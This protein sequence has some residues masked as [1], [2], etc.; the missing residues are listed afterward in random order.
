MT[1]DFVIRFNDFSGGDSGV[2]DSSLAAG[3]Q[4][5]GENMVVYPSGL[6]GPRG[7]LK[8][9]PTRNLPDHTT[10]PGP[11]GFTVFN[12]SLIIVLGRLYALPIAG[13]PAVGWAPYPSGDAT[14]MVRFVVGN[15]TLYS[16]TNGV[17]HKHNGTVSTTAITTPAPLSEVVRWGYFFVGVDRN[18]PWRIWFNKVDQAGSDFDSWP[19]NNYVDVGNND[20]ITCLQPIF[21][22]LY[23]GKKEG[24]WAVSGVLGQL[25]SV[26]EVAIGNGPLDC[27]FTSVTTDNRIIYW[28][29]QNIPAW[30]NGERVTLESEQVMSPRFLPFPGDAVIVTPTARRLLLAGDDNQGGTRLFA[31]QDGAWQHLRAGFRLGALAPN[32]VRQGSDLPA[33]AIF[34]VARPTTIGDPAVIVSHVHELNRPAHHD[35]DWASPIDQPDGVDLISGSFAPT[36]WFDSQGRQVRVRWVQVQFRKWASGIAES[37]NRLTLRVESLGPYGAGSEMSDPVFWIEPCERSPVAGAND[38]W[39]VNLGEQGWGNGF[40]LHFDRVAGCAIREIVVGLNLRTER[41]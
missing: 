6:L 13:G 33:S 38:S 27:R 23:A 20:A 36:A 28:P 12:R 11:A 5:V 32:D 37:M 14:T 10:V 25:A 17:L 15:G 35:D 8:E 16:L 7:G 34:A 18:R 26:R 24:W 22:T 40:R 21:N 19:V 2:L 3:N 4:F 1:V 41:T 30:F 9:F 31:F 29:V 39:R